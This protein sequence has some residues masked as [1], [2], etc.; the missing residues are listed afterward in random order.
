MSIK[1]IEERLK[2]YSPASQRDEL[3]SLKEIV[4]EIGLCALARAD[5]FKIAAFQGGSC[6]R[7]IHKLNRFSEDL[8]FIM[9]KP[10]KT[11]VWEPFLKA[12]QFEFTLYDLA[13]EVIDRSKA[14]SAVKLAF[15]KDNSFGK[16]LLFK[17]PRSSSD[18]QSIQI[19]L[20]IDTNPPLGSSFE[21][22]FLDFPYPFSIITQDLPSL[23][24][25]KCHALL[26]RPYVKGR[27]WYDFIWYV[28]KKIIPNYIHLQYALE[29]IGPWQ[30]QKINVT[31]KW[32]IEA[33]KD[34]IAIID[35]HDAKRDA[36]NFLRAHER[37]ALKVWGEEFF[38]STIKKFTDY[39]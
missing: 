12:L 2:E 30:N 6:L 17:H 15:L 23:F 24:A 37:E 5:F 10:D 3:N 8:D 18:K 16:V 26:C 4:Q 7:I 36:E 27:D 28:S 13:F 32:L 14:D 39:L 19:K 38:L 35:W 21:N 20:E 9:L 29:Q 33:L 34:K 22:N 31:D 11:F 1:L 25:S